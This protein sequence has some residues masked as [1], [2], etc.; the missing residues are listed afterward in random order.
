MVAEFEE[1]PPVV[2]PMQPAAVQ[3]GLDDAVSEALAAAAA[4]FRSELGRLP[5]LTEM[6][7]MLARGAQGHIVDL[8][9]RRP[10]TLRR[11]RPGVS[12]DSDAAPTFTWTAMRGVMATGSPI[13]PETEEVVAHALGD[14]D[15]R[16]RMSAVLA[17]GRLRLRAL[18]G[19]ARNAPVP[20]LGSGVRDEDRRTLLALR[21]AAAARAEGRAVERP[22]HS[23]A[24]IADKRAA[25]LA[26]VEAA[27]A[28]TELPGPGSP[29]YVLHA[30]VDPDAVVASGASPPEWREW[31]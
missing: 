18:A 22:V 23:D 5:L 29:A 7:E 3:T 9:G 31:L 12:S 15:W 21:E 6:L 14:T 30:L 2:L 24:A 17:V 10:L 28:G 26:S 1:I 20:P 8:D 27:V 25:F 16:A 13:G 11:V 4:R 19:Q